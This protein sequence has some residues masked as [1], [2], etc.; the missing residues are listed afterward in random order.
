MQHCA[1]TSS[2]PLA[3]L[4]WWTFDEV[5]EGLTG[6]KAASQGICLICIDMP[7]SQWTILKTYILRSEMKMDEAF[8][9][10]AVVDDGR[11]SSARKTSLRRMLQLQ[12]GS[13]SADCGRG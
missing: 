10:R 13:F 11:S 8:V 6:D 9:A 2:V 5:C 12:C 1:M 3:R 7:H 4:L